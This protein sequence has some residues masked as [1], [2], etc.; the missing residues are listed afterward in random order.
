MPST[1]GLDAQVFAAK[2]LPVLDRKCST[3]HDN[4]APTFADAQKVTVFAHP[5]QSDLFLF[6]TGK[7]SGHRAVLKDGSV[8]YATLLNWIN[9]VN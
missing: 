1:P 9:G 7:K 5:E 3:C 4:P 2:V 8:E 6:A